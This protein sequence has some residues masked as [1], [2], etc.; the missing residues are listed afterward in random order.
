MPDAYRIML[1]AELA[2]AFDV[3]S[4]YLDADTREDP[5]VRER[6]C[7]ALESAR[8]AAAAGERESARTKVAEMYEEAEEAGLRWAPVEPR[9]GE[10]DRQA[11]DY[12]KDRL[13]G[14]MS[15]HRR[16]RLGSIAIHL[17]VATR[18]LLALPGLDPA[19]REDIVYITAR[20]AMA[21]DLDHPVAARRELERLEAV[22]RRHGLRD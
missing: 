21:L 6:L 13:R 18:R 20:A 12:A 10:A 8:E 15:V 7:S 11:R 17:S 14:T 9:P 19:T 5:A 16:E 3:W 22:E 4:G 2:K 1:D